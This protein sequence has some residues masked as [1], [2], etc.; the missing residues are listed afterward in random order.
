MV[1]FMDMRGKK[2]EKIHLLLILIIVI[3]IF[4]RTFYLAWGSFIDPATLAAVL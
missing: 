2:T 4:L 1:Y 3:A